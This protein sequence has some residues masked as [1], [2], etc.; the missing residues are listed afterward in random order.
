MR[1]SRSGEEAYL[2]HAASKIK[3]DAQA[4]PT[5]LVKMIECVALN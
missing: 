2:N 3:G 4:S 5:S 1:A